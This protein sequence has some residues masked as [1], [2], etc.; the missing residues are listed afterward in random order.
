V[1][2]SGLDRPNG[3]AFKDGT[4]YIAE[5]TKISKLEKIED[6]LD[7]P[8]KP[9][10]IYSD[11]ADHRSHGWKFLTIGPDNKLYV[12]V[13]A[14]C[15]VCEPPA[16]NAQIRRLNTDGSGAEPYALGVRNSVASTSTPPTRSSTSPTTAA[17]CSP[18]TCPMTSSMGHQDGP[19]LRLS[20]LPPGRP[21]GDRAWHTPTRAASS[22]RRSPGSGAFASLGMRFYNRHDVPAEISRRIFVARHAPGTSPR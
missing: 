7:S 2:A 20:I 12:S 22:C 10:V 3:L 11:F 21:A 9:V 1:I 4:L 6:N 13:G 16:G 19:A 14:P 15:N 17:T 8:P 5:G 18:T